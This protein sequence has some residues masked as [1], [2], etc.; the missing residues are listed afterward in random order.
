MVKTSVPTHETVVWQP[1][2]KD[3]FCPHKTIETCGLGPTRMIFD[4]ML[5]WF[6]FIADHCKIKEA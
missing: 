2:E 5:K 1:G 3:E 6:S 4:K